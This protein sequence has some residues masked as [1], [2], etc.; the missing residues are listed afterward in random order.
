MLKTTAEFILDNV[1]YTAPDYKGDDCVFV[2][3]V[4]RKEDPVVVDVGTEVTEESYTTILPNGQSQTIFFSMPK[5]HK[6]DDD[7][8]ELH[9]DT[10]TK[11]EWDAEQ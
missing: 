5:F 6:I 10:V 9:Y 3:Y 4:Y 2:K 1:E 8:Y 7:W 11:D